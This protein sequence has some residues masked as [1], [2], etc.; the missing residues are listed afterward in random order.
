MTS[1]TKPH[2]PTGYKPII[3]P[4]HG[5]YLV[6]LVSFLV[7]VSLAQQWT[8]ESTL[9]LIC[10]FSGFQA[11]QPLVLQI[12]QRK[13]WQPRFLFWGGIY[14][15][16]AAGIALSINHHYALL[17][18]S[19]PPDSRSCVHRSFAKSV[20]HFVAFTVVSYCT[21]WSN[22]QL[23]NH[24]SCNV[25]HHHYRLFTSLNTVKTYKYCMKR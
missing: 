2:F 16:I 9:A 24:I 19:H 10:A 17:Y 14:G 4:E 15:S 20:F 1:T 12:K 3:S 7:G 8:W 11:E 22:C 13:S 6:L 18:E 25:W 23:R 21:H 5:V